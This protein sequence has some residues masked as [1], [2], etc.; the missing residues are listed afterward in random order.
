MTAVW[1]LRAALLTLVG[2]LGVHE[3]RYLFATPRHEHPLAAA[4]A[5]LTWLTPLAGVLLFLAIAELAARLARR[6]EGAARLPRGRTLW[7][8][9]TVA[10][11]SVFGLQESLET[12]FTHGGLP[13][14]ADLVG[15]GGWTVLPA[16]L[17]AGAAIA[18][19][20]RGAAR[21]V[22]WIS[23]SRRSPASGRAPVAARPR[24]VV[25]AARTSVLARRLAG[26]APPALS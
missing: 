5:Y 6:S 26:R 19:L 22:R 16:A 25:L 24:A 4:H 20:L 23:S 3:V 10:L 12:L 17:A 15:H 9:S 2:V 1:R 14:Q 18:L 21:L 8:A 7:L 11:L 13:Q